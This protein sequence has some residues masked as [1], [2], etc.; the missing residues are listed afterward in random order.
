LGT[1]DSGTVATEYLSFGSRRRP[2]EIPKLA[3]IAILLD[4]R[5]KFG[6]EFSKEDKN[7]IWNM[8]KEM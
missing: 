8:V 7:I 1:G 5:F 3:L 2:K 4:P 6:P